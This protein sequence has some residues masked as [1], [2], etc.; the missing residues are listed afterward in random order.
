MRQLN[1]RIRALE[2]EDSRRRD[3]ILTMIV[4]FFSSKDGTRRW[5]PP[6]FYGSGRLTNSR[7]A[8]RP[9]IGYQTVC[10]REKSIYTP[11]NQKD[12]NR[13]LNDWGGSLGTRRHISYRCPSRRNPI[14]GGCPDDGGSY[15]SN[16]YK[17]RCGFPNTLFELSAG[18][19]TIQEL[20]LT[21]QHRRSKNGTAFT[22]QVSPPLQS[23]WNNEF[24]LYKVL[25][26]G[27]LTYERS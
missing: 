23:R 18:R 13:G 24:H 19:Q 8:M 6:N 7:L 1:R 2:D 26:N 9:W 15:F 16:R 25:S 27:G 21:I 5:M 17:L 12:P 14:L 10:L 4:R 20:F 3:G 22:A 11:K